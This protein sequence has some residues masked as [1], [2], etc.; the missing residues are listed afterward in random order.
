MT[1]SVHETNAVNL[2][3]ADGHQELKEG[4]ET[5]KTSW[6]ELVSKTP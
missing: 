6:F 2:K 5:N 1:L 4:F 3:A